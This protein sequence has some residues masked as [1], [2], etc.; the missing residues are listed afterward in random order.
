MNDKKRPVSVLLG[1]VPFGRDNIGDE[2]ILECSVALLRKYCPSARITVAT[3]DPENTARR[4]GVTTCPLIGFPPYLNDTAIEKEIREHDVF[5][6]CGAT[7]LSDYPE[8]TLRL[9]EIAQRLGKK[10][11]L[12]GVGM[13]SE[14]NP[15]LYRVQPGRR[16]RL[17]S[18]VNSLSFHAL[19]AVQWQEAWWERRVHRKTRKYLNRADLIVVRD[20]ETKALLVDIGITNQVLVGGDAAIMLEADPFDSLPID[21]ST[22]AVLLSPQKK[23]GVCVSAQRK[24]RDRVGLLSYLDCLTENG[25]T[26]VIFIPM[27]PVTDKKVMAEIHQAMKHPERALLLHQVTEPRQVMSV[28]ST[29]DAVVSSRLH[30][31]IMASNASVPMIGIARGSKFDNYLRL[32]GTRPAGT[33]QDCE[34]ATLAQTTREM[35]ACKDACDSHITKV[36]F[37]FEEKLVMGAGLVAQCIHKCR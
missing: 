4:L 37:T 31:L 10:T 24:V 17:L 6:W 15:A 14:L 9:L 7:G 20:E 13:N 3:G 2:A 30:L 32:Y 25:S 33:V 35:M 11:I 16:Q 34:F 28:V 27:N 1:G 36:H 22:R 8:T 5:I 18:L 21:E 23:L 19:D 12:W 26:Q 29:L